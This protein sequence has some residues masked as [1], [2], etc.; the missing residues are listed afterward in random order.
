MFA[1][2]FTDS[3][4]FAAV[5]GGFVRTLP[6]AGKPLS[7]PPLWFTQTCLD[8]L[9]RSPARMQLTA[10]EL[11]PL[12]ALRPGE[13]HAPTSHKH[14]T[15]RKDSNTSKGTHL[16]AP[17]CCKRLRALLQICCCPFVPG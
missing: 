5:C 10:A 15:H 14:P 13:A 12:K 7:G 9:R 6:S 1:W 3:R 17:S 11:A 16:F 2:I 4:R 8:G